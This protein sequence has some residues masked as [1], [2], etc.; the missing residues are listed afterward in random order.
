VRTLASTKSLDLTCG[1]VLSPAACESDFAQ[2]RI[3][4]LPVNW[5]VQIRRHLDQ[6][7][8]PPNAASGTP[9][10]LAVG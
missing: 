8:R 9:G 1:V 5:T 6:R 3:A 4:D 2:N 7:R 10:Q